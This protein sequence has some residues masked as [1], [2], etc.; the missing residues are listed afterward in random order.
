[1]LSPVNVLKCL[2]ITICLGTTSS[3]A[4][5]RQA[6]APEITDECAQPTF[7]FFSRLIE[8]SA[9]RREFNKRCSPEALFLYSNAQ[10]DETYNLNS[11]SDAEFRKR[12]DNAPGA[13]RSS[14]T[15]MN[16]GPVVFSI[17]RK[18]IEESNDE[19]IDK[20][21]HYKNLSK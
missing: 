14:V 2:T 16:K 7:S 18:D 10:L 3:D 19:T 4:A 13:Q 12:S 21:P 15:S 1:M 9:D 6:A 5:E 17:S 8:N 11:I 20:L